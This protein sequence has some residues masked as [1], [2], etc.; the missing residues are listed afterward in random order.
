MSFPRMESPGPDDQTFDP[1]FQSSEILAG[2]VGGALL[3]LFTV[4]AF[5]A[6]RVLFVLPIRQLPYKGAIDY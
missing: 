5:L 6:W 2:T 4:V 1:N 3:L